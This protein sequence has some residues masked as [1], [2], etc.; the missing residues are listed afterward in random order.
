MI[1][2][3]VG[4]AVRIFPANMRTFTKETARSEQGRGAAWQGNGMGTAWAR[5]AMC[6]SV[7]NDREDPEGE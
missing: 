3:T 6:E 4:L 2:Y 7:L 5:H 1:C